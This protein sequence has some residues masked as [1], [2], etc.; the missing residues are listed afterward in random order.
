M[1]K[2]LTALL[3]ITLLATSVPAFANGTKAVVH[4]N[5]LVCD[6]CARSLEKTF[7]KRAEVSGIQVDLTAKTATI[8]FKD[9][10]SIDDSTIT[11]LITDSG[12]A[13]VG[14]DRK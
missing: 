2:F 7:G 13:V 12:Y 11:G 8:D 14:I 6:F 9:G 5:G 4:I 10:Q 1:T 3:T